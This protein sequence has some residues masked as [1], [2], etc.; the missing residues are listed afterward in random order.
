MPQ[1]LQNLTTKPKTKKISIP[2]A[3]SNI[4]EIQNL[5]CSN[6]RPDLD[7]ENNLPPAI[8]SRL[9]DLFAQIE[10]EFELL[11]SENVNFFCDFCAV[12]EKI[13]NLNE[14]LERE[15]NLGD[16]Q[17]YDFT[18][19]DNTSSKGF[20]KV[21]TNASQK[22]KTA[23]KLKAQTS[24]IVSSFKGPTVSCSLVREFSGHRD[25]IWEVSVARPG[26]PYIGTASADHTACIW[27]I[28]SGR[29]LLRYQG[30][31]GSVNSI[32]FHPSRDL[33][34]TASGDQ[35]AHVWQAVVTWDQQG[36]SSEEELDAGEKGEEVDSG[37]EGGAPSLRTPVCELKGHA[38][39]VMA[40]DWLPGGDQ[41]ITASWDRTAGLH[42]AETGE[43]V[44]SLS[45]HD[46]ELTHISSH[47]LQ[48]L[49]VTSSRDTTFRLWDFRE[50]IHSVSV[51]QGHTDTVTCAV[52]TREDKVVSGSDDRSVKVW[53]L[54]NMRSPLATIRSD[55]A[56]NRLAVSPGGVVAIPHDNRQVRLFD[57][58]GQRIARLPRTSRQGHRRMVSSVAWAED[59]SSLSCNFFSCG[60]DRLI[61][62]WSVQSFKDL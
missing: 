50:P 14:R 48:R 2:R 29:C 39:V 19:F 47:P 53:D 15:S 32:R 42:D 5:Q 33:V 7:M 57:L 46:H 18:D 22:V 60:F 28:E 8:R 11:Y 9:Q 24:K 36:H 13:E 27:S 25:G 31:G 43:L 35:T 51:F 21:K 34:L 26:Q 16:K 30:H 10:K 62:G 12:Q 54:R 58:G 1:D 55:S 17:S 59:S 52:F 37:P 44:Q 41:A 40:A 4:D 38:A 6:F 45:G 20:P 49:V 56:A 61:L 23:H 3:Q